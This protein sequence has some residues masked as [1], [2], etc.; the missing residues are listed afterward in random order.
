[1]SLTQRF[2]H[3][4]CGTARKER[5]TPYFA[6]PEWDEVRLDIAPQV[7][8]DIVDT[9]VTLKKVADASFDAVFSSHNIEHLYAHEVPQ[10]LAS[11]Y[12]VLKNGGHLVLSCPDLQCACERIADGKLLEPLYTSPAGPVTPLDML[13]GFRPSLENGALFMAHRCGFVLES[14]R[15]EL[16]AAGFTLVWCVRQP[17]SFSLH[18]VAGKGIATKEELLELVSKHFS[19]EMAKA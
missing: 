16:H 17:A 3:V 18:A 11:F 6:S 9:I 15:N 19:R 14:L 12:R 13:Y 5:S 7:E 8:P 1:M 4:G 10:A 2:L